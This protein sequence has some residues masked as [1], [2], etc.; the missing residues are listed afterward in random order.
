MITKRFGID[1]HSHGDA[2]TLSVDSVCLDLEK[3]NGYCE[4]THRSGWTIKAEIVDCHFKW[5]NQFEAF[6]VLYGKLSGDFEEKVTATSEE[7]F[8][9]FWNHHPPDAWDYQEI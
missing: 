8:D 6:H 2:L 5:V 3:A 1:F 7:A 9:H 4:R